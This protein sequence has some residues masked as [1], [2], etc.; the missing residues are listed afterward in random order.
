MSAIP[1]STGFM[2]GW[3][4]AKGLVEYIALG[5]TLTVDEVGPVPSCFES[6]YSGGVMVGV[7]GPE[8]SEKETDVLVWSV[9]AELAPKS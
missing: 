5:P 2:T 7:F 6:M 9:R 3:L 4:R 8:S 1:F